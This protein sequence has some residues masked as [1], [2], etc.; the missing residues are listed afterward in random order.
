M[1]SPDDVVDLISSLI[2][3]LRRFINKT[4]SRLRANINTEE[5]HNICERERE[6][7]L[8]VGEGLARMIRQSTR[9]QVASPVTI[10]GF[11]Q[12][13]G[14]ERERERERERECEYKP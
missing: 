8:R 11:V 3:P 9:G 6:N 4:L 14:N 13:E 10:L 12:Q 1:A 2:D 7:T 5:G